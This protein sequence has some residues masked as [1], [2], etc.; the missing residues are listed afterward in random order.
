MDE[1]HGFIQKEKTDLME[2]K[3]SLLNYQVERKL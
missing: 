2:A 3:A 1:R